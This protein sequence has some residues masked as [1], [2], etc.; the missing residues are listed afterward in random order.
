MV[1]GSWSGY[2]GRAGRSVE[3]DGGADSVDAEVDVDVQHVDVVCRFRLENAEAG[4]VA[5]DEGGVHVAQRCAV[6]ASVV[7]DA[8]RRCDGCCE[9]VQIGDLEVSLDQEQADGTGRCHTSTVTLA[10]PP[11]I[12][13]STQ[14]WR[15]E[16]HSRQLGA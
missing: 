2:G 4:L 3:A 15:G 16:V 10:T 7:T 5:W 12:G 1:R 6:P 13:G 9:L 8:C 14:L 11:R